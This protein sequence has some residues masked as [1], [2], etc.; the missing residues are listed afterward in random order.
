LIAAD[1]VSSNPPQKKSGFKEFVS[2]IGST[3]ASLSPFAPK[4]TATCPYAQVPPP[5]P[6]KPVAQPE[7]KPIL[8]PEDIREPEPWRLTVLVKCQPVSQI[9]ASSATVSLKQKESTQTVVI[10]T[11]EFAGGVGRTKISTRRGFD[12]SD[13]GHTD[14]DVTVEC[15]GW[16]MIAAK[17]VTLDDGDKK[18]VTIEIKKL[19]WVQFKVVTD[20]IVNENGKDV[21]K[22]RPL[23]G[24]MMD[25]TL[26]Q[27]EKK[28]EA[29]L[30]KELR[31]E[32]LE[33]GVCK[34]TA[35]S[36]NELWEFEEISSQ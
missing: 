30:D 5:E 34:V 9:P 10:A 7:P 26:P 29:S 32:K 17:K 11:D 33:D 3:L 1:Q 27:D 13:S 24:V 19:K 2:K 21:K 28:Q 12:I 35:M 31:F 15:D 18:E 20:V 16:K 8:K 4:P 6:P 25:I 22:E 14:Y 23:A 36:H